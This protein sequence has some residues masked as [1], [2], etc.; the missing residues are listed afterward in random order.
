MVVADE[1]TGD[2]DEG[3]VDWIDGGGG[4]DVVRGG[5]CP[6]TEAVG[7]MVRFEQKRLQRGDA[8]QPA[9]DLQGGIDHLCERPVL[10]VGIPQGAAQQRSSKRISEPAGIFQ[11]AGGIRGGSCRAPVAWG[12]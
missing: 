10:P 11:H 2:D 5:G 12:A 3:E 6:G 8:R 4:A 7:G 1:N 9:I